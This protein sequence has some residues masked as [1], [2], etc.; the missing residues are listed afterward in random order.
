MQTLKIVLRLFARAGRA[1]IFAQKYSSRGPNEGL[2]TLATSRPAVGRPTGPLPGGACRGS[3]VR[4]LS[5]VPVERLRPAR[6][7][8]RHGRARRVRAEDGGGPGNAHG[9]PPPA[10]PRWGDGGAVQEQR[11]ALGE[12]PG[13]HQGEGQ[14]AQGGRPVRPRHREVQGLGGVEGRRWPAAARYHR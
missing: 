4:I 13:E 12:G 6:R 11:H 2:R 3:S 5:P 1:D 9:A 14:D 8:R 10:K 7:A